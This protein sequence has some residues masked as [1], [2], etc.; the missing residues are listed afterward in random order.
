MDSTDETLNHV[1]GVACAAKYASCQHHGGPIDAPPILLYEYKHDDEDAVE[2]V[3]LP[4][5]S[6]KY[7][8]AGI[9]EAFLANARESIGAPIRI[10]FVAESYVRDV[11][12]TADIAQVER[13]HT[14]GALQD[15][16]MNDPS[17]DVKEAITVTTVGSDG[18]CGLAFST[19]IYGDD[20]MPTF[21]EMKSTSSDKVGGVVMEVMVAFMRKCYAS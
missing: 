19:F 12:S 5:P 16:F 11:Q 10:T 9:L 14:R 17:S 15:S 1:M 7:T 13:D 4:M 2:F 21:S 6:E 20:G 3:P 8:M 18:G